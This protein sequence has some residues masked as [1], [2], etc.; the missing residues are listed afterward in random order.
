VWLVVL[1]RRLPFHEQWFWIVGTGLILS[2]VVHPWY[3]L[4]LLQLM[5][6]RRS[7]ALLAGWWTLTIPFTYV[8]LPRWWEEYVWQQPAWTWWLQ[9]GGL[10]VIGAA[11]IV[12]RRIRPG[13]P[14]TRE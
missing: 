7:F 5:V 13:S 10:A 8:L 2:P 3:L 11:L 6:C 14:G 12:S 9:Y 4:A 1:I